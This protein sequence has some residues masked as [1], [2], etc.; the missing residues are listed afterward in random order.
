MNRTPS[1]QQHSCSSIHNNTNT[2]S[3]GQAL[4]LDPEDLELPK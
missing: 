4:L 3:S 2:N 1:R